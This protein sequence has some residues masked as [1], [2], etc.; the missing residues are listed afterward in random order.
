M[1][2]VMKK[3]LL[4]LLMMLPILAI[5]QYDFDTRYF[6][7]NATSLTEAP[8]FD[9]ILKTLE[10]SVENSSTFTLDATPTFAETLNSL[11]ISS[12][13]YWEPV[14]MMNAVTTTTSYITKTLEV[15][16]KDSNRFGF[17]GYSADASS[18][19]KNTVYVEVRGLDL[20]DPCPPYG[21]CPRCAP[22]RYSRGY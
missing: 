1:Y 2:C 18:K 3:Q 6:T 12:T 10:G 5:G 7:I 8:S 15:E 13:N 16:P 17:S 4:L 11:R 22:Y 21:I 9:P 14:D 19:V 20:L